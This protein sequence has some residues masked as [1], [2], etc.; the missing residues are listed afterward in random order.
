MSDRKQFVFTS[1]SVGEGHPDK[2]CDQISD[3]VLDKAIRQDP[4]ARVGCETFTTTGF[5]LVGGEI[6]VNGY[7]DIQQIVRGVLKSIGYD[8]PAY[9]IDFE[10]CAMASPRI[11]PRV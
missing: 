11:F 7:I 6:T 8:N 5:V 1:E 2:V 4:N 10:S 9:G 3:A